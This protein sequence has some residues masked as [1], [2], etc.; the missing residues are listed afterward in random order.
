VT[1]RAYWLWVKRRPRL[2]G[3]IWVILFLWIGTDLALRVWAGRDH[4]LREFVP[5]SPVTIRQG[6]QAASINAAIAGW[7]PVVS[8][9]EKAPPPREIVPQGIFRS[10]GQSVAIVLLKA[11]DT[12]PE[13]RRRLVI[14]D[15]VEGST[16]EAID[17]RRIVLTK[18]GQSREL[19]LLRGK[20]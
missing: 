12:Q 7:F 20:P 11:N 14:G 16:V 19:V 9:A 8:E 3:C 15:S 13:E 17:A 4:S 1:L 18:D 6:P 10:A 2:L 5:P